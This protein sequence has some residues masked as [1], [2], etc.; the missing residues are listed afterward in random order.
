MTVLAR[1]GFTRFEPG[2]FDGVR[3][4][5]GQAFHAQGNVLDAGHFVI[6]GEQAAKYALDDQGDRHTV[7]QEGIRRRESV[8]QFYWDVAF[9][10]DFAGEV[11]RGA[12]AVG[13]ILGEAIERGHGD[14]ERGELRMIHHFEVELGFVGTGDEGQVE[15][16]HCRWRAQFSGD[17]GEMVARDRADGAAHIDDFCGSQGRGQSGHHFAARHRHLDVAEVQERMAA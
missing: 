13:G 5:S 12:F 6:V 8:F 2:A 17:G 4:S 16:N 3:I 15:R 11:Q 1:R 14:Q 9:E 10:L 7:W